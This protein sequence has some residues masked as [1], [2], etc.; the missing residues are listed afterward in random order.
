MSHF[1]FRGSGVSVS[2]DALSSPE[3]FVILQALKQI[4]ELISGKLILK[5][6]RQEVRVTVSWG[7]EGGV[8]TER[9][10]GGADGCYRGL[11]W[12]TEG[13]GRCSKSAPTR[14]GLELLLAWN[15]SGSVAADLLMEHASLRAAPFDW[16]Q[17]KEAE[18]IKGAIP[19]PVFVLTWLAVAAD[20]LAL[21]TGWWVAVGQFLRGPVVTVV[22]DG[23][24]NWFSHSLSRTH[25]QCPCLNQ[26]P[27]ESSIGGGEPPWTLLFNLWPLNVLTSVVFASDDDWII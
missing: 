6:P 25:T 24:L 4:L 7:A 18:E 11:L 23:T 9:W 12:R 26:Q 3:R 21:M 8:N 27:E 10:G 20:G 1:L 5:V 2:S 16:L 13:G 14:C 17:V 22:T 19:L 15:E